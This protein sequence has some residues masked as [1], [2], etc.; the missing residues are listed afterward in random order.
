MGNKVTQSNDTES[1]HMYTPVIGT[2]TD[3][4][5]SPELL[6]IVANTPTKLVR[7]D[8]IRFCIQSGENRYTLHFMEAREL[9]AQLLRLC[10][11]SS[12]LLLFLQSIIPYIFELE[13]AI[14]KIRQDV[15]T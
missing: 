9:T 7:I 14:L 5:Y 10:G 11:K 15:I 13:M 6:E 2:D 12:S 8:S 1:Q 3:T 4:E